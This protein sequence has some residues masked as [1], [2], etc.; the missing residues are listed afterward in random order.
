MD[1]LRLFRLHG[2]LLNNDAVTC[3]D[4]M[5]PALTSMYLQGLG[6]PKKAAECSVLVNQNMKYYVHTNTCLLYTSDAADELD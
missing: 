1:S 6:L 5:I 4:R 3:H 2:G